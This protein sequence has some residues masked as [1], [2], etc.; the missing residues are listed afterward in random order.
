VQKDIKQVSTGGHLTVVPDA[1]PAKVTG[2][3][4]KLYPST[5]AKAPRPS[6]DP[7]EWDDERWEKFDHEVGKALDL[8]LRA[9]N[10]RQRGIYK[11][12]SLVAAKLVLVGPA[13]L[14]AELASL[15]EERS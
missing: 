15:L 4:G 6:N 8:V 13:D 2:K 12:S 5:Q 3:D 10:W 14:D 11:P 1:M 7:D 9:R